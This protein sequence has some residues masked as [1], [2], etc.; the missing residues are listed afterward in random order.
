ME[1]KG[2]VVVAVG[3]PGAGKSRFHEKFMPDAVRCC[4]YRRLERVSF[5]VLPSTVRTGQDLLKN[6]TCNLALAVGSRQETRK[7]IS[8][9]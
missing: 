1:T 9:F 5:A 2:L 3:L 8:H 4:A 7:S 6:K